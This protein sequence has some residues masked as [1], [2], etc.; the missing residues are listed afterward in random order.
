[1]PNRTMTPAF[2]TAFELC[3]VILM[4]PE[5]VYDEDDKADEIA[6]LAGLFRDAATVAYAEREELEREW[7]R[8]TA[9]DAKQAEQWD[10]MHR[11][12]VRR[13]RDRYADCTD[14]AEY[15]EKVARSAGAGHWRHLRTPAGVQAQ[16]NNARHA[17]RPS[18]V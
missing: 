7:R 12:D 14:A 6:H 15:L 1:M 16:K 10:A 8:E 4:T 17:L 11:E 5:N 3:R 18:R 13:Y 2:D 9:K